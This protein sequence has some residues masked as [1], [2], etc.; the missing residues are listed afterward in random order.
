MCFFF[1][2]AWMRNWLIY[3][4]KKA[5]I[6]NIAYISQKMIEKIHINTEALPVEVRATSHT[7]VTEVFCGF[8]IAKIF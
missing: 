2:D 6:Q 8:L 7:I 1:K 5:I 3:S 4:R